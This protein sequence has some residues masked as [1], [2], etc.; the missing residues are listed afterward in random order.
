MITGPELAEINLE[1]DEQT[2]N[3]RD[4]AYDTGHESP[5]PAIW[6]SGNIHKGG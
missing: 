5:R 6:R 3:Q 4:G 2:T 1:F